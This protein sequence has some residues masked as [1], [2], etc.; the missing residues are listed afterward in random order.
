MFIYPPPPYPP[1]KLRT[2]KQLLK[3]VC[4]NEIYLESVIKSK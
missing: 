3:K 2:L 1:S 4:T